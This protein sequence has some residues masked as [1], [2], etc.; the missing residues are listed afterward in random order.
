[1][2]A[3]YTLSELNEMTA[4]EWTAALGPIFEHS[5]W[6]AE[7]AA[8]LRPFATVRQLHE[9]MC[10]TVREAAKERQL[11]LLRAHPD[12]A[13]RLRMTDVSTSEQKG[14]GL[15][16]LSPD[17]F[18]LF[19]RYNNLY[20]FRFGFPFIMAVRGQTKVTILA[21]MTE[22]TE[23]PVDQEFAKALAEVEKIAAFR[24]SDCIAE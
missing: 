8:P 16:R 2:K 19:T 21:A 7:T 22:R 23:Q 24:L 13:S 18:E 12:L 4:A 11:A 10:R 3:M 15:D 20:T 17:E 9:A 14:A 5:P 1:M 6:V